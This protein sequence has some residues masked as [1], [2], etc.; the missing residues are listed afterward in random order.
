MRQRGNFFFDRRAEPSRRASAHE[1]P[2]VAAESAEPGFLLGRDAIRGGAVGGGDGGSS[3]VA[4]GGC[5]DLGRGVV[6]GV[7]A[8]GT[9]GGFG[10]GRGGRSRIGKG[11]VVESRHCV[12]GVSWADVRERNRSIARDGMFIDGFA[13]RGLLGEEMSP[14]PGT[15]VVDVKH[16]FAWRGLDSSVANDSFV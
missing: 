6:G 15:M 12:L 2:H 1:S 11:G 13:P 3:V 5:G 10:A 9:E 14:S 7:V 4:K 8:K 16:R